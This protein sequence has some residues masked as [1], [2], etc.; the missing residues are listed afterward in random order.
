MSLLEQFFS[1]SHLKAI[2]A[3]LFHSLWQGAF[4]AIAAGAVLLFTKKSS[5]VLRHNLLVTLLVLFSAG[6]VYTYL[7]HLPQTE[8]KPASATIYNNSILQEQPET[9]FASSGN[10][11]SDIM[12]FFH[13]NAAIIV[14]CWLLV[15]LIR[16][17]FLVTGYFKVNRFLRKEVVAAPQEWQERWLYLKARMDIRCQADLMESALAKVPMVIGHLR[18]LV[19]VPA[20]MLISL[21]P[22]Q[23]EAILL[24]ELAH[25]RR[26][27]YL[28]NL[29]QQAVESIFFFHPA[30]RWV[31]SLISEER[32][33]CCDDMASSHN[34]DKRI[35]IDALVSF[36]EHTLPPQSALGF[37]GRKYS[38]VH[39]IKR[40]INQRNKTLNIM[41]KIFL[42][43]A[44]IV[45]AFIVQAYYYNGTNLKQGIISKHVTTDTI[46][47]TSKQDAE[48]AFR[49]AEKTLEDAKK[50]LDRAKQE[51]KKS[52]N[53]NHNNNN[54]RNNSTDIEINN[55]NINRIVSE[56]LKAAEN[57]LQE[58]QEGGINAEEIKREVR[59]ALKEAQRELHEQRQ[60][61][62]A[63]Q[64]KE[65]H[66]NE[67]N[68]VENESE[69]TALTQEA[70]HLALKATQLGL[71]EANAEINATLKEQRAEKMDR[72]EYKERKKQLRDEYRNSQP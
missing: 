40:L 28:L 24:H 8:I 35:Y 2:A 7:Y 45:C 15:I 62:K 68:A 17:A 11:I 4:L 31:S 70:V 52:H 54:K 13:S 14:F 30:V 59:E 29:V 33:N 67:F 57:E 51:L 18:P 3:M 56:A 64:E 39:R 63:V 71:Q 10:V 43:T 44:F 65:Q 1:G 21:P 5:A 9:Q 49:D 25:I 41:E 27:D 50:E 48:R 42:T 69:L 6:L 60:E 53:Q 72:K 61:L 55:E 23:A 37:A 26:R 12:N 46:P 16:L 19:L 58:L 36:Y 34:P 20:G 22:D 38:M 47:K 32:E 66:Q